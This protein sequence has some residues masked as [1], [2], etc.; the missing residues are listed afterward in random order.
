MTIALKRNYEDEGTSSRSKGKGK[1]PNQ[2]N[3]SIIFRDE[4]HKS[5]YETL[6]KG[7]IVNTRY[8]VDPVLDILGTKDDIY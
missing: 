1:A 2:G 8:Q 3:N 7:K 5:R 4:M 6:V